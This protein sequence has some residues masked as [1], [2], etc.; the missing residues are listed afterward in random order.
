MR[1]RIFSLAT[2]AKDKQRVEAKSKKSAKVAGSD[3][4]AAAKKGGKSNG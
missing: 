2:L 1:A 3:A 4:A